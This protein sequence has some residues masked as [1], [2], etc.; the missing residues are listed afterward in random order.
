MGRLDHLEV[1]SQLQKKKIGN[2]ELKV[3]KYE[4]VMKTLDENLKQQPK[5]NTG[6]LVRN[7][8]EYLSE[9]FAEQLVAPSS[10]D[11]VINESIKSNNLLRDKRP[12]RLFPAYIFK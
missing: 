6:K 7:E 1:E 12:A 11:E 4:S 10:S 8:F 2:L 9:Y 5:A 3:K